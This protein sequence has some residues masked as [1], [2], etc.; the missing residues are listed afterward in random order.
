MA[1]FLDIHGHNRLPGSLLV[2]LIVGKE[3]Q[4]A[5]FCAF[6]DLLE[7]GIF[8]H[9]GIGDVQFL[10]C[11][12]V[13]YLNGV[14][15]G[16]AAVVIV[17]DDVDFAAAFP[18]FFDSFHPFL[19][20]IFRVQIIISGV[21]ARILFEP[22]L[23]ITAMKPYIGEFGIRGQAAG[24]ERIADYRLVNVDI[25][26]PML[27]QNLDETRV[28][29]RSMP[30]LQ[31]KG[32]SREPLEERDQIMGVGHCIRERPWELNENGGQSVICP[33]RFDARFEFVNVFLREILSCVCESLMQL[34]GK[35]KFRETLYL[36]N[37]GE[38]HV[39][40]RRPVKGAVDLDH[41]DEFPYENE[42]VES[43]TFYRRV[44]DSLPVFV[45]PA[46]SSHKIFRHGALY[47]NK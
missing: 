39:Q 36:S 32:I 37:P 45:A 22:I 11:D 41:S 40:N 5:F 26:H 15:H 46:C 29:P 4:L 42:G 12:Q 2:V 18:E 13:P 17:R 28:C 9:E 47:F 38:R 31:C 43:G 24:F 23:V 44:Y 8:F 25:T 10:A 20:F 34:H 35:K 1:S 21:S 6:Y 33:E 14:G 19:E 7:D 30:D 16:L 3:I 27:G